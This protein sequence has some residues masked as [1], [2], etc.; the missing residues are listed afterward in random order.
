MNPRES[1]QEFADLRASSLE[2]LLQLV[3]AG[4]GSTLV[5]ALAMRGSWTSGSGVVARDLEFK[6][7]YRRVSLVS[8]KSFP[9]RQALNVFSELITSHLPNTVRPLGPQK[10]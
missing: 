10:T 1:Q 7:A 4:F 3:G 2:T 9:R 6:N 5:P 8:R